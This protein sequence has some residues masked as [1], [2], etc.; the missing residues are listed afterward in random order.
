MTMYGHLT[1]VASRYRRASRG[2]EPL[3]RRF[4]E[5]PFLVDRDVPQG[6]TGAMVEAHGADFVCFR[7]HGNSQSGQVG[8]DACPYRGST[9][10]YPT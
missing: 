5:L 1:F 6:R 7:I 9:V 3:Q 8:D 10:S 4:G 2:L